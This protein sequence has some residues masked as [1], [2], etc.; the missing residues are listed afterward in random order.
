MIRLFISIAIISLNIYIFYYILYFPISTLLA[1]PFFSRI[2]RLIE[3]LA[4]V[5][6]EYIWFFTCFLSLH[7]PLL[8]TRTKNFSYYK[9]L[10]FLKILRNKKQTEIKKLKNL[11]LYIPP[12]FQ[13]EFVELTSIFIFF[14]SHSSLSISNKNTLLTLNV[15]K[16]LK[17]NNYFFNTT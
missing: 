4:I 16:Y 15:M 12:D 11:R 8:F 1:F 14:L 3:L 5:N 17:Q 2:L 7:L 9:I 6:S 10:L 13:R